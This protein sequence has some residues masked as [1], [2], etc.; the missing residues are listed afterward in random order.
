MK[1]VVQMQP[2]APLQI[3]AGVH[4]NPAKPRLLAAITAIL[5]IGAVGLQKR[6]LH[7]VLRQGSVPQLDKAKPQQDSLMLGRRAL[8]EFPASAV[9]ILDSFHRVITP[10]H[11]N[12][13]NEG[14]F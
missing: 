1:R 12:R 8:D 14:A 3:P 7:R 10:F 5:I 2:A 4:R 9:R 13:R 6:F 11:H